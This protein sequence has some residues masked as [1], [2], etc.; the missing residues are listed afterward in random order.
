MTHDEH[1]A[2]PEAEILRIARE[3]TAISESALFVL[4]G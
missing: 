1:A 4:Q 3:L 2:S